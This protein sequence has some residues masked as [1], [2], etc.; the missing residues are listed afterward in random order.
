ME[1]S[2]QTSLLLVA[3][4]VG[5][6]TAGSLLLYLQLVDDEGILR[7]SWS[8]YV[9]TVDRELTFLRAGYRGTRMAW[10]Q[11]AAAAAS[12]G[13]WIA[14]EEPLMLAVAVAA[15]L[16][17][18]VLLRQRHRKRV[19]RIEE[20]LDG[21]LLLLA[22]SLRVTPA[23]G[24]A[25]RASAELVGPPISQELDQLDKELRLGTPVD[26]AVL[27]MSRRIDSRLVSSALAALLV[28]RQ[29]GG[30]LASVLEQTAA[31]LREMNRLEGVLRA[32]TAEGRQQ[33]YVLSAI[34]FLLIGAIHAIDPQWLVPLTSTPLGWLVAGAATALWLAALL[35]AR[36]ILD[37]SL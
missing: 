30:D 29:T 17:P 28:A 33:A 4:L 20:Q 12:L 36:W 2:V 10:L 23:L 34:P 26:E 1:L 18:Y 5:I 7:G 25:L 19:A 3:G 11:V 31:A 24:E 6:F 13:L 27:N 21:W 35:A 32:K 15:A 22:N 8:R 14:W 16:V 9:E 37:V